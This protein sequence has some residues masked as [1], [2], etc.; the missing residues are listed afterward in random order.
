VDPLR[1]SALF[2]GLLR[3][4]A[5]TLRGP[6]IAVPLERVAARKEVPAVVA[7]EYLQRVRLRRVA[8]P[9]EVLPRLERRVG[10]G[11]APALDF[12]NRAT[13]PVGSGG[14]E[15]RL[16][17]RL[18]L[19]RELEVL[20]LRFLLLLLLLLLLLHRFLLHRHL[21]HTPLNPNQLYVRSL[22]PP[23]LL[24][25][26]SLQ[27][28]MVNSLRVRGRE[29]LRSASR[30]FGFIVDTCF[31]DPG[32][33][34]VA[35]PSHGPGCLPDPFCLGTDA[36]RLFP[37]AFTEGQHRR[38]GRRCCRSGPGKLADIPLRCG[39]AGTG[40]SDAGCITTYERY[41]RRTPIKQCA[42]FRRNQSLFVATA[43]RRRGCGGHGLPCLEEPGPLIL[44]C[45]RSCVAARV[46][47]L[48]EKSR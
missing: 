3:R 9:L 14:R 5:R 4:D 48:L 39:S 2:V 45:R 23:P 12:A 33:R 11:A 29:P 44:G 24:G 19:S 22:P 28:L 13:C 16:V 15:Q 6:I 38:G 34:F 36:L 46:H 37:A 32:H 42:V 26:W 18:E 43:G 35:G 10:V 27:G 17:P 25:T 20:V 41:S 8:V 47:N 1:L 30:L 40:I 31:W 7:E 21:L